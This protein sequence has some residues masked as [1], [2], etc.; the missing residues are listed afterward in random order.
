MKG[1]SSLLDQIVSQPQ[2][3]TA[4][5]IFDS[6]MNLLQDFTF[7]SAQTETYLKKHDGRALAEYGERAATASGA[8]IY[9]AVRYSVKLLEKQPDDSR[10]VLLLI[11]ETRDHGSHAVKAG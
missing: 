7:E 2:V 1:I 3:Q 11:S 4:I 10:H 8:A 9:D 5:V 6:E